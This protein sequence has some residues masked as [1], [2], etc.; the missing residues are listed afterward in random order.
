[1]KAF[2]FFFFFNNSNFYTNPKRNRDQSIGVQDS[3]QTIL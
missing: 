2:F 1:M 3:L